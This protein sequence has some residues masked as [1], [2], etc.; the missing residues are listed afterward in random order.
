[1]QSTCGLQANYLQ[2]TSYQL[3]LPRFPH[4]QYYNTSFSL[5]DVQLPAAVMATPFVDIP[6]AGD[7]PI[8]GPLVFQ[9]IV[10]D[11]L[12]NYEEILKWINSIGFSD[13]YQSYTNY[14]T[15]DDRKLSK[16]GEQDAKVIF[17]SNKSNPTRTI[18][19]YDAI[20][21]SLSSMTTFTSQT[22][23]VQYVMATVTMRYSRFEFTS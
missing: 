13:N 18:T 3:V 10:T 1:M 15:N 5:P 21:V 4:V 12:Q 11:D 8:F 9:F 16:L 20:P 17:L 2:N 19:F 6:I 7:K 14:V 22:D 23:G